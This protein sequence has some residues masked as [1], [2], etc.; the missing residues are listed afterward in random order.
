VSGRRRWGAGIAA[1]LVLAALAL[2]LRAPVA[3]IPLD[4]DEGEYAYIAWRWLEGDVPY[5]DTFNQKPPAAPLV[6][7]LIRSTLGGSPA[8]L[9]WGAQLWSLLTLAGVVYLGRRL[10]GSAAGWTSGAVTLILCVDPGLHGNAVNTELL[11]LLPLVAA[12]IAAIEAHRSGRATLSWAAGSAGGAALLFKPVVAPILLF[13]LA[14]VLIARPRLRHLTAWASGGVLAPAA[15]AAY[16]A[17]RGALGALIGDTIRFNVEYA[18]SVPLAQYPVLAQRFGGTMQRLWPIFALVAAGIVVTA[19]QS[20]RGP[21]MRGSRACL[22][23]LLASLLAVA[24]GGYFREHYFVLAVPAAALLAGAAA[25]AAVGR[26]PKPLASALGVV[27]ALALVVQAVASAPWYYLPG[28]PDRKARDIYGAN[29][30]VESRLAADFVAALTTPADEVFVYG[31]EPQ[32]LY[33][34]QRRSASR[35]LILYGLTL[36]L[37]RAAAQQREA[38]EEIRERAPRVI[39]GTF[40]RASFLAGRE[41]PTDLE[42]GVRELIDSSYE[43]AGVVAYDPAHPRG[44]LVVGEAANRLWSR[45]PLWEAQRPWAAFAVWTRRPAAGTEMDRAS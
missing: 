7:A 11:A 15:A 13:H 45:N 36:P 19:W 30:F 29:P 27:A 41:T 9:R 24:G 28:D 18:T 37:P 2:V 35:Y 12:S 33:Y 32:V 17:W 22:L 44:R 10:F 31:S 40:G 43:L 42:S 4:R 8:E 3:G 14:L 1:F 21:A 34:S 26:A 23:W 5:R 20:V 6:Y 39:V 38:I 16:F 25:Q